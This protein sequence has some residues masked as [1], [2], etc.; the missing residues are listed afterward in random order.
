MAA[1]NST[2]STVTSGFAGFPANLL[3]MPELEKISCSVKPLHSL[4]VDAAYVTIDV[5]ILYGWGVGFCLGGKA[6]TT[7]VYMYAPA[8]ALTTCTHSP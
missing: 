4:T 5:E 6:L 1:F 2:E 8:R 3:S 7:L